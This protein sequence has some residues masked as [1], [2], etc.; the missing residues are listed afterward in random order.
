MNLK[1]LGTNCNGLKGKI[2]SLRSC[3]DC[4]K[5]PSCITLQETKL[6]FP[7]TIYLEGYQIF[8]RIRKTNGGGLLSAFKSNLNPVLISIGSEETE[9]IVVQIQVLSIK[10]RVINGYGPQELAQSQ[11]NPDEQKQIIYML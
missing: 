10:I 5:Y 9:L 2:E 8:E 11:R 1:I 6:N 3:I 7:G 4:Y